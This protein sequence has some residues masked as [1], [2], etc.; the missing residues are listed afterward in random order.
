MMAAFQDD[1]HAAIAAAYD[2]SSVRLVCDVDGGVGVNA[3]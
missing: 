3:G 1:R 2:F